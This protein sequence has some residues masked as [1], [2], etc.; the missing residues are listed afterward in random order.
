MEVQRREMMDDEYSLIKYIEKRT[1]RAN[2]N[3]TREAK[4]ECDNFVE[5]IKDVKDRAKFC[6]Y[7][8]LQM[9]NYVHASPPSPKTDE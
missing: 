8:M 9:K 5:I 4:K 1:R 6:T 3:K 7:K 2:S